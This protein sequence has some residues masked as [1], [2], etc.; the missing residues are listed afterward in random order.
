MQG[1]TMTLDRRE[2]RRSRPLVPSGVVAMLL[3]V[4]TEVMLFAGLISAHVIY[5]SGQVGGIWPPQGQPRLPFAETAVNSAA[6]MVSGGILIL[7]QLAFRVDRRRALIPLG[8]SV[9]LGAFFVGFQGVE[10]VGLIREGLTLKSSTYGAFFYVIVG[11]H[12]VHAVVAITC[13]AWAWT[14]L[15]RGLLTD[16]QFKGVQIFWYFVVLV[17]PVIYFQVYR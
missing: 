9:L 12:A 2:P 10:W 11:A 4:F 1:S 7:A 17:W 15:R 8:M 3:F 14:R 16:T 6:L 13:L 5:I